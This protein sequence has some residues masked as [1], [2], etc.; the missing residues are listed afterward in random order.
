MTAKKPRITAEQRKDW[1][2]LPYEQ[3][4]VHTVHAYFADMNRE[5][6]GVAEYLPMRNWRFEQGRIKQALNEHGA[7]LLH[8]AFDECFRTYRP[9]PQYP[10][11]TA[12]FAICY[13][14]NGI[15]P[16]LQAEMGQAQE[17]EAAPL[18]YGELAKWL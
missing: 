18:D 16:Q 5:H 14:I 6:Y 8:R 15:I 17:D 9:S 12:G 1:R 4:N 11:L 7:E 2:N 3:W 13:R 10:L